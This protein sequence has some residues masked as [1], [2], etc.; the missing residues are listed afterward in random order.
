MVGD[1]RNAFEGW[2]ILGRLPTWLQALLAF[3]IS[4]V[5]MLAFWGAVTG[6]IGLIE[7]GFGSRTTAALLIVGFAFWFGAR[8]R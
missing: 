7:D 6:G 5:L 8:M 4:V 1:V 3:P 2:P